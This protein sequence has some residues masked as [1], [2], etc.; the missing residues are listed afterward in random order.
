MNVPLLEVNG[1]SKRFG[2]VQALS[3][4]DFELRSGEV[5]ALMGENG[6]GKSTLAKIISGIEIPDEGTIELCGKQ[7]SIDNPAFA[8][9]NGISIVMQEFNSMPHLTV[10]ENIFIGHKEIYKHG[11]INKKEAISR[12]VGLLKLFD[13]QSQISPHMLLSGLSVAEQQIVEILKAVSYD[14]QII[15]MDEPTAALSKTEA[16][17]LFRVMASL[18]AKGVGFIIVSHRFKEIFEISDRITVLRDGNLVIEGEDMSEMTE[19]KLV[20]AMVGR[21][22]KEFFGEKRSVGKQISKTPALSVEGL[23]D[24]YDFLK[25]ISFNAYGGEILGIAG[26]IGAGRTSLVRSIFGADSYS[27]GSVKVNGKS[28]QKYSPEDAIKNGMVLATE[29][30]KEE[31]LLLSLSVLVNIAFAKT[32]TRRGFRLPHRAEANESVEMIKNLNIKLGHYRNPARSLSGGNQQKVVIAK[33][34]LTEPK[35]M[36]LDEPT[37]GIDISAKSEIY[38]II[39][40]LATNGVAIIVVSSELPEILG[41]CDRVLIMKDGSL[42]GDLNVKGTTEEHVMQYASFGRAAGQ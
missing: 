29:N 38:T 37:R 12:T 15:I 21:E 23:Y 27:Q 19:Q 36:I 16:D 28:I 13:M 9:D 6:A 31:G 7:V 40:E 42:V 8:I 22:I 3:K 1:I 32:A 34:L 30:R 20:R 18:K 11:I 2:V 26:L 10:Y 14:S 24:N 41:I 33:W 39:Q 4:V 35:V 17:R 5:H 25:D